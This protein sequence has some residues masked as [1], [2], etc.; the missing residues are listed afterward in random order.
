MKNFPKSKYQVALIS[1]ICFLLHLICSQFMTE[2]VCFG[3][4]ESGRDG[5]N[6]LKKQI[7]NKE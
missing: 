3:L 1:Y 5:R 6:A 2:K 4:S 7:F